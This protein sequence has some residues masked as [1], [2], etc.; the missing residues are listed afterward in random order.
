MNQRDENGDTSSRKPCTN[1]AAKAQ[2]K[3]SP[4]SWRDKETD[5]EGKLIGRANAWVSM[6]G[7][8][9]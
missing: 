3:I 6:P 7:N 4:R 5:Y 9:H 8:N 2:T 1:R